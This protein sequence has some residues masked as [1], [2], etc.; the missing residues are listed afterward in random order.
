MEWNLVSFNDKSWIQH[1]WSSLSISLLPYQASLHLYFFFWVIIRD[2]FHH[3][4]VFVLLSNFEA[5]SFSFIWID[6]C[7]LQHVTCFFTN[8]N[9]STNCLSLLV[10]QTRNTSKC[11][12]SLICFSN[13]LINCQ[14]NSLLL[15]DLLLP[16]KISRKVN[17][18]RLS[19]AIEFQSKFQKHLRHV[20]CLNTVIDSSSIPIDITFG[21]TSSASGAYAHI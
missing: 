16:T 4:A 18:V 5:F 2:V 20:T 6:H 8:R 3:N 21:I 11:S 7:Q 17:N 14:L 12:I 15:F 19:Y 13:K 1:M 9:A 10:R